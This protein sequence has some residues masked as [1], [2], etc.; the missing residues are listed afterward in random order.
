MISLIVKDIDE[1]NNCI[2][3]SKN[4][5]IFQLKFELY[6]CPNLS[7]GDKILISKELLDEKSEKYCRPYAFKKTSDYS[8]QEIKDLKNSDYMVAQIGG[9]TI[10]LKRIYG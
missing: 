5:N 8:D 7:V 10:S 9:Q 3:Q 1:Y 6:D 4:L 2:L